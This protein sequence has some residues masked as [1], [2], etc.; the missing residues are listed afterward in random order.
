MMFIESRR[1]KT[2]RDVNINVRLSALDKLEARELRGMIRNARLQMF[3]MLAGED[4]EHARGIERA[5]AESDDGGE[6]SVRGDLFVEDDH[7]FFLIF[8]DDRGE[9]EVRA[10]IIHDK[11]T[12]DPA[13][14]LEQFC[15]QAGDAL[16]IENEWQTVNDSSTPDEVLTLFLPENSSDAS[17][18]TNAETEAKWRAA[19][20]LQDAAARRFL[21]R[22]QEAHADNRTADLTLNSSG[23]DDEA[24]G[25]DNGYLIGRLTDAGL[26]RR[27]ILISCRQSNRALFRLPSADAL[28]VITA[29]RAVCSECGNDIGD[30]KIEELIAPTALAGNLLDDGSWL[31]ARLRVILQSLGL[32][33]RDIVV[34]AESS[35]AE[36]KGRMTAKVGGEM[37]L[38]HLRDGDLTAKDARRALDAGASGSHLVFVATGRIEN[39]ARVLLREHGR[40]RAARGEEREII[41]VEGVEAAGVELQHAFDRVALKKLSENLCELNA[42]A[43]FDLARMIYARFRSTSRTESALE[44]LATSAIGALSG[45]I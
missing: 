26:L 2:E 34:S 35:D 30:E 36:A 25:G 41:V 13:D 31:V 33:E 29:S 37:F 28:S 11:E 39:E 42:S 43:G 4:T 18:H 44:E 19:E 6:P 17:S 5:V 23:G 1:L 32:L 22:T 45:R 3:A 7:V 9:T 8:C 27:E 12:N 16:E 40:R 21:R 14:R 10:G 24:D 15:R 20:L 38:F